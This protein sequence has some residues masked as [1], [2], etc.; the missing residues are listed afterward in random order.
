M[1][2]SLKASDIPDP[3]SFGAAEVVAYTRRR[4]VLCEWVIGKGIAYGRAYYTLRLADGYKTFDSLA[5]LK[6]A[7]TA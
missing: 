6:K 2:S 5:A 1:V 3:R 7:V 4:G